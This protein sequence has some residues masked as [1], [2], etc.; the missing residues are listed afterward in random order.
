MQVLKQILAVTRMNVRSVPMRRGSSCVIVIGIAGVVG[1]LVSLLAMVTGLRQVMTSNGR[2]DRAIVISTGSSFEIL[3]NLSREATRTI[4]DAPGIR[5]GPDAKPIASAEALAIVRA[6]L[7]NGSPANLALRG[8]GRAS[9][10]VRPELRIV[11]GRTFEPAR[12][13]LIVGRSAQRQFRELDT[14]GKI[15]LR[16]AE[17]TIVGV[18]ESNGD[19]R[20][21][22]LIT[23]AETLQS[24]LQAKRLPIGRRATRLHGGVFNLQGVTDQEPV[25]VGRRHARIGLLPAAVAILHSR[26]VGG[27]VS[28]RRHHGA[29]G[30]VRG[31]ERD[32]HGGEQPN[33]GDRDVACPGLWSGTCRRL[34][35]RRG[36]PA[37]CARRNPR[38]LPGVVVV[39]W[40]R[41]EHERRRC[42][43]A[44]RPACCRS[45]Q[46]R[47]RGSLGVLYR[48]DRSVR[49]RHRGSAGAT[50]RG[51]ACELT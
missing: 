4:L 26:P 45:T 44:G 31:I 30:N 7:K 8:A 35:V 29:R 2:P 28:R 13:E 48:N 34:C 20:E 43:A 40:A 39:R 14:D 1:V 21:A 27:C 49:S 50:G 23:G 42:D 25:A 24:V 41:D 18:F 11:E 37:G 33:G 16:G 19:Q 10:A 3:S 22:E 47:R 36:T 12:R 15:S 51:S 32:V 38:S 5:R 17:W 46:H 6:V 9:F